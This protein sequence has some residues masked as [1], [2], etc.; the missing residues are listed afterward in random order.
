VTANAYVLPPATGESVGPGTGYWLKSLDPPVGGGNLAVTGTT[1]PT[2]VDEAGGCASANGCKAVRLNTANAWNLVGNPFPYLVD[3]AKVRVRVGGAAGTVYTPSVAEENG[4]LD[5]QLWIW[6]GN[7]YESWSDVSTPNPGN[8]LYFQSFWVKV[9]AGGIGQTIELLIPAENSTHSQVVPAPARPVAARWFR[10]FLD[11]LVPA[12]AADDGQGSGRERP[13]DL[14]GRVPVQSIFRPAVMPSAPAPTPHVAADDGRGPGRDP[15]EDPIARTPTLGM[16]HPALA[17]SDPTLDLL[18]AEGLGQGL[19]QAEAVRAAQTASLQEGRAWYVRLK[20]DQPATRFKDYNTFLGQLLGA[21]NDYDPQDLV[22]L[23]PFSSPYLT[24]VFPHPEWGGKAGDYGSDFRPAT[25][26][27]AITVA[28]HWAFPPA[29]WR[30]ELRA[31]PG[32]GLV[33][34][35]WEGEPR[36]L[37]RSRLRD[38]QTGQVIDPSNP[39]F[40]AGYPLRLTGKVRGLA[41][42]F[43]GLPR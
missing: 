30:L 21:K 6:N 41:W 38:L 26:A 10:A 14:I 9:L 32:T 42:E 39:R 40:A 2:D 35:T 20:V 12:A 3:W 29:T 23:P 1:T 13:T 7:A 34:L 27:R 15:P 18:I 43:L 8:L 24:L 4:Y 22:E 17:S 37:K 25:A 36:I 28:K 5:R 19:G 11:W 33:L 31:D 16:S